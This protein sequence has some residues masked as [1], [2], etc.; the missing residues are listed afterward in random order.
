MASHRETVARWKQDQHYTVEN[1]SH[2]TVFPT[3]H[4]RQS[5]KSSAEHKL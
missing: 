3:Y 2:M 4:M 1:S 5:A